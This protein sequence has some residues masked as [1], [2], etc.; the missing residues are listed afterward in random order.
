MFQRLV[1]PRLVA[2]GLLLRPWELGDLPLVREASDDDYIPLVTTIPP[3]WS[4]EAGE[5]FVRRQWERAGSGSGY[6]FVIVRLADE[7][8]LGSI[9]LWLEDLTEGRASTG[10]WLARSARGRG[11]AAT[12][13][14][15]VARWAIDELR[16]PRLQLHV[17]PWNA[18]SVR[19]AERTGFQR[20]G[21]LRSWQQVGTQRRDM[22]M[23]SLLRDDPS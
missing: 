10:Y 1:V 18:A 4:D 3:L 19:T 14:R 20:E 11:V 23:Y 16:I 12:A 13:L 9:G 6:P 21:L 15:M 8:P 17:E 2:D 22:L 5:A 7:Q